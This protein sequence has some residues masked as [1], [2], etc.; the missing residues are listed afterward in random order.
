[1]FRS[2]RSP[3][4]LPALVMALALGIAAPVNALD[5]LQAQE[6]AMRV[7][8]QMVPPGT[9]TREKGVQGEP[10]PGWT[11]VAFEAKSNRDEWL[12]IDV[13]IDTEGDYALVGRLYQVDGADPEARGEAALSQRLPERFDFRLIKKQ[14]AP[15]QGVAEMLYEVSLPQRDQTRALT[16][17]AGDGFGVVGQLYGPDNTNL[18][19]RVRQEW[20]AEQVAWSDLVADRAPV[21]GTKDAP[22]QI[23]MFTDPDCPACQRAKKR[24]D[25]LADEYGDDL[26]VYM[27]W[28]P[29]PMHD[30]AE[31]KAKALACSAAQEQK[32]LFKTLKPMEP[33]SVGDVYTALEEE[34]VAVPDGVREC[35]S[36]GEAGEALAQNKRHANSMGVRSVPSVYFRDR[37]Y[38]GFPESAIRDALEE[39][40]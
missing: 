31:P 13:Y 9:E 40:D 3:R 22:V 21:Y 24:I 6:K 5:K 19:D 36:A 23:A 15:L 35:V 26:G 1:M 37:L 11:R 10:V 20:R 7:L 27:L 30:H 4:L 17:Y 25:K 32:G 28:M 8:D 16:V 34:G 12:P 39:A 18:S 33:N 2:Y 29:L 38:K 14:K